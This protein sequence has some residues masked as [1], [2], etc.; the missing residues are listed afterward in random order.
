MNFIRAH[1]ERENGGY[2]AA[3]GNT[4][5]NLTREAVGEHPDIGKYVNKEVVFGIRPE[6]IEDARLVDIREDSDCIQVT[7]QVIESMGS[8]KYVY[9]SLP[10]E[11]TAHLESVEHM[12]GEKEGDAT[13]DTGD[14]AS[15]E[16]FGDLMVGR[17]SPES[18]VREGEPIKLAVEADKIHL[19]DPETE[20][21]II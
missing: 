13:G 16:D 4:R 21:A 19:F 11:L 15:A 1:L 14:T 2:V 7:P 9:F 8:E 12:T 6:H 20:E 5:I 18:G 10:R 17:I 3:F